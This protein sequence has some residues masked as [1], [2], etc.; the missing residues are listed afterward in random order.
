MSDQVE[1]AVAL[2]ERLLAD[3]GRD[4]RQQRLGRLVADEAGKQ[5]SIGLADQVLRIRDPRRA[6][7]RFRAL[8]RQHGAPRFAGPV[9]RALLVVGARAA[10]VVPTAVVPLVR[11]RLRHETGGV[12]ISADDPALRKHIARRT[13]AGIRLNVNLLGEAILGEEEAARRLQATIDLAERDDVDYVS[14][15][16]SAI[17]SQLNVIAFDQSV[18]LVAERLRELYR[19]ATAAGTF[20]NLDMEEYR[21]LQLTT[22]A[23]MRVL[24]EPELEGIDAGI[25]LQAY[26]PDSHGA[27]AML[28]EWAVARHARA[29]AT[30][31]VRVVKGANLAMERVE[32]ELRDWD[33]APYE[34]KAEVDASYK[35]LVDAAMHVGP[36]L[37]LGVGSHNLYDVAWALVERDR[38]DA[39]S[40]VEIEMLE[41]MAE[42]QAIAVRA[43]AGSI[44]L[45]APVV[46]STERD[47]AIAYLVRR[48]EENAAPENFL[49]H[50][51]TGEGLH[52]ERRRFT[53]AVGDA[54]TVS[55]APR[56]TQDRATERHQV[57]PDA[58]FTNEPDTDFV[59]PQNRAWLA[60]ELAAPLPTQVH[61]VVAGR[62]VPG[63]L[64]GRDDGY[65]YVEG[66]E[67][68]VD[69]AVGAAGRAGGEWRARGIDERRAVV[70]AVGNAVASRRGELLRAMAHDTGKVVAEGDPEVSEAV[71]FARWYAHHAIDDPA[72]EPYGTVVVASP[73]NFPLAI[74]LG[75]V[76]AALAA[77][78]A[79]ILKPAPEAVL[80]GRLLAEC[81]W[82]AG[83]PRD[84]LQLLPVPDGAVGK[85][86]ITH[87]GVD[88]VVLTG[89]YD[90]AQL[91]LGWRPDLRLHAETSGK[92]ALVIT[93]AADIDLAVRDLVR[94]AFGHA[95]QK[96]SA[97]SLAIVE[98]SLHDDPR[99][100]SQLA[101][102]VRS[103]PV[104]MPSDLRSVVGPLIHP[105][106]GTLESALQHLERGESWLVEPRRLSPTLWSPGV[107]LGVRAGSPFH[108]TECFGP[109]LG[110]I[111][112]DSLDEAIAVQ[113][114]VPFGLTGGIHSLDP[115][116]IEHWLERVEVGNAYV[117][118]HITGAIVRRQPFGGWKRSVVG[119][120]VKAGGPHYVASLGRWSP[121]PFDPSTWGGF[122]PTDATGLRVEANIL[123]YRP[124]P[125]GV[126]V[127]GELTDEERAI[128]ERA[129]AQTGTRAVFTTGMP[130]LA[131]DRLR[132]PHGAS[133]DVLRAAHAAGV[134]VDDQ[135][136][137]GDGRVEL[138][139]WLREQ[140]V[141]HTLHRF[142][143]LT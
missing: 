87:P 100:T 114:A 30:I 50:L 75:G 18:E 5:L 56:R 31:K 138:L 135:P 124:L 63:P 123:R 91:F 93:A 128:A 133:D 108:V 83:V 139:H 27:L 41:G 134:V 103:L 67:A 105:P 48:L 106:S 111:R 59:L 110:V 69:E 141:S 121:V 131:V 35:R 143:T 68:L 98:G 119:P 129:S 16:L 11:W 86:L 9:D 72:F 125:R 107:K 85:R 82:D 13:R 81:C 136:I 92:N 46:R 4:R 118:R 20:V 42:P 52:D 37:R 80:V 132:V 94:S 53:S 29:G 17:C 126:C 122:E 51:F 54:A 140:A 23:F 1:R 79:V 62:S 38:T 7:R 43:R 61:A 104:G 3:S 101:D 49:R 57:G 2:A 127:Q 73:W 99:F 40:R 77:G 120:T 6:A 74:P 89:S 88:A 142:G 39:T 115:A 12:I 130:D 14:V 44:L 95:G 71:D 32:A 97:A 55:T 8:V 102:A 64:T 36:A 22:A 66:Y 28:S 33:Q 112:V 15:K 113:N 78:S 45:Y 84:V 26:L 24:D 10:G 58:P 21:D 70:H 25:V 96:C 76:T 116:E 60:R 19:R 47:S 117:N 65:R 109:V 137:T 34:T 90:T